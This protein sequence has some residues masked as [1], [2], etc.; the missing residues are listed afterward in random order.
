MISVIIPTLN[1]EKALPA[2]LNSLISQADPIEIIVVDGGS[3]DRTLEIIKEYAQQHSFIHYLKTAAGRGLQ[4]NKGATKA[5]G[6]W[7]LFLHA[8]T[9]LPNT[10]IAKIEQITHQKNIIAGCFTHQFSEAGWQLNLI[11][12][13]HNWRF[14][15]SGIIYG[16][17]AMFVRHDVFWQLSGFEHKVMEDV[18]FCEKLIKLSRPIQLA[19]KVVTESRK[20]KQIGI[21]RAFWWMARILVNYELNRALP[22][23][24]FFRTYR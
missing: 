12:T 20:F 22:F 21:A 7:L 15:R 3:D 4:M 9:L 11:S 23:P 6:N 13:L 2:T 8:D 1:E 16:D 19:E 24:E 10:G 18:R 17:Q 14:R 5:S